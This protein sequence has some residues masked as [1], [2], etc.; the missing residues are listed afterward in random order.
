MAPGFGERRP[1]HIEEDPW[2]SQ[3][4]RRAHEVLRQSLLHKVARPRWNPRRPSRESRLGRGG[5]VDPS[6]VSCLCRALCGRCLIPFGNDA[7]AALDLTWAARKE[8]RQK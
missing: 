2:Q 1:S 7:Q 6:R 5:A 4:V 8:S 3:R